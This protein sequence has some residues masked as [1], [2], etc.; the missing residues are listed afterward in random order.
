MYVQS[1]LGRIKWD[2]TALFF[3]LLGNM[4][5]AVLNHILVVSNRFQYGGC[6]TPKIHNIG[7]PRSGYPK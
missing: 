4:A 3:D 6:M 1:I 7:I 5:N 2:G